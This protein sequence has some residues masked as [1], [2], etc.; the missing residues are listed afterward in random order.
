[1]NPD[2]WSIILDQIKSN[3]TIEDEGSYSEDKEGGR[4][5]E[6]IVFFSPIGKV[7]LEFVTKPAVIDRKV[8]YSNRIG[9]QT[10]IE[11]VYSSEEKV[12][13]LVAYKWNDDNQKWQEI[14]S[15]DLGF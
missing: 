8:I 9:S 12:Y 10:Q 6:F 7:K 15:S 3:F 11:Y 1:M 5:V 2:K 4:E 14:K 13:R